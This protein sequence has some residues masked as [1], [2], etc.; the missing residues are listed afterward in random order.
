MILFYYERKDKSALYCMEDNIVVWE[1][2]NVHKLCAM[3]CNELRCR[4]SFVRVTTEFFL[5]VR[6]VGR[7]V[8]ERDLST[9]YSQ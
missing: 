4:L 5:F 6:V 9:C 2:I 8:G 3:Q 1:T 7:V